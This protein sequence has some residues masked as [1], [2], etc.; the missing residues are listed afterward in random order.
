MLLRGESGCVL[1][2]FP[3]ICMRP[4]G[5][6]QQ[7]YYCHNKTHIVQLSIYIWHFYLLWPNQAQFN[8]KGDQGHFPWW[9]GKGCPCLMCKRERNKF[10]QQKE[11]DE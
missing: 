4:L 1:S 3:L 11:T 7:D 9:R 2:R 8:G 5:T 6:A 10:W